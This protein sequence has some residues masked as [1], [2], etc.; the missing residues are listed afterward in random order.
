MDER[1]RDEKE[2]IETAL[3]FKTTLDP[4]LLKWSVGVRMLRGEQDQEA[5]R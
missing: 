4:R 1:E 2:A 5:G 3:D